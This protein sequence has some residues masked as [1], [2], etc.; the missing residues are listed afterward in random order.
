MYDLLNPID[1]NKFEL[2]LINK[3]LHDDSLDI[4]H[5]RCKNVS[6]SKPIEMFRYMLLTGSGLTRFHLSKRLTNFNKG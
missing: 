6:K 3:V 4:H 1:L 2:Q 5:M